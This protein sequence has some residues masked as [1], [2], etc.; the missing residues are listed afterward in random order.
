M[1]RS[2]AVR[3]GASPLSLKEGGVTSVAFSP[4]GKTVAAGYVAVGNRGLGGVVLWDA[5]RHT[6]LAVDP[7]PVKE[8]GVWSIAFSPNDKTI[9]AGYS[10]GSS[11]GVVLWDASARKRLVEDPLA[12]RDGIVTSVA[13]SP[14]SKTIAAG[15]GFAGQGDGGVVLFDAVG[16][17]RLAR[18]PLRVE[19]G[20]VSCVTFSPDGQYHRGRI[21]LRWPRGWRRLGAVGGGRAQTVG[22]RTACRE[23]RLRKWRVFQCRR[24]DSRGWM[25]ICWRGAVGP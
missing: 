23:V 4:D 16:H 24:K 1:G 5:V 15:Y 21:W 13:F 2:E 11:G 17:T 14:D 6:R 18:D 7:L 10:F 12:I 20:Y 9:A 22:G 8:G 25:W 19:E 3:L